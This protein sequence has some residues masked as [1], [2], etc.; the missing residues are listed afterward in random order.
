MKANLLRQNTKRVV[1]GLLAVWL[2][3]AVFLFCCEASKANVSEVESCPLKKASHCD[4]K[5]TDETVTQFASLRAENHTIDCCRFP[6]QVFDKARKLETNQQ[7]GKVSAAVKVS[8]PE[9]AIF[10][11]KPHSQNFHQS[12]VRDRGSTFLRNCVFR[13]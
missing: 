2:S 4:K 3:G 6:A 10:K 5:S 8:P 11:I 12:V 7:T 9:F 13:I 1:A